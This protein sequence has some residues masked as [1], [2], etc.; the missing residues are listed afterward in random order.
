MVKIGVPAPSAA[1]IWAYGTRTLTGF[2]GTPRSDL[3]GADEAIYT[4]LDVAV[5]TRPSGTDYTAARAA[6]LDNLDDTITS[7]QAATSFAE[8][9]DTIIS[10][11]ASISITATGILTFS[12]TQPMNAEYYSDAGVVWALAID[13]TATRHGTII[14]DGINVRLLNTSGVNDSRVV[15]KRHAF[16][17]MV[18]PE[19]SKAR[20]PEEAELAAIFDE[21]K[22]HIVWWYGENVIII[23]NKWKEGYVQF[24][25]LKRF[26]KLAPEVKERIVSR[27]RSP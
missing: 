10:P 18:E 4:R 22:D 16:S 13:A 5:S 25:E 24:I 21:L 14:S 20:R 23:E 6:K 8:I 15:V 3:V 9:V 17:E 2:T 12:G 27:L 1:E 11:S 7:R 19:F 26:A